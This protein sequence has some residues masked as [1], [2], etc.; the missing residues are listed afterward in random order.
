MKEKRVR[1]FIVAVVSLALVLASV[2]MMGAVAGVAPDGSA[3]KA[4]AGKSQAR[5]MSDVQISAAGDV[6]ASAAGD[7]Q[8]SAATGGVEKLKR[9]QVY[10]R[11]L[12]G[13]GNHA[14]SWDFG[15]DGSNKTDMT[16]LF[17]YTD[18]KAEVYTTEKYAIEEE[19]QVAVSLASVNADTKLVCLEI[20]DMMDDAAM[21]ANVYRYDAASKALVF[22]GDAVKL[23]PFSK[24]LFAPVG[25]VKASGGKLYFRWLDPWA[26]S[27]GLIMFDAAFS[28]SGAGLKAID[29]ANISYKNYSFFT[30]VKKLTAVKSFKAFS[31]PGG[32]KA[33]FKVKKGDKVRAVQIKKF[34]SSRYYIQLKKGSRK[35]WVRAAKS[36]SQKAMLFK[37]SV[38][39]N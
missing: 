36:G 3:V 27:I 9:G 22:V 30:P 13:A 21:I 35:G 29:S 2:P 16:K 19:T 6:Q 5:A 15:K 8:A 37:E 31:T 18:G 23:N 7:V 32:K 17:I 28:Y 38:L 34:K 20:V 4:A 26:H 10:T 39:A 14:I 1:F 25:L 11:T 12:Q 24:N 33:K